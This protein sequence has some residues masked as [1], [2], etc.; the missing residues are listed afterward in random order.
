MKTMGLVISLVL[1]SWAENSLNKWNEG[2]PHH[3]EPRS[4]SDDRGGI[5]VRIDAQEARAAVEGVRKVACPL[6]LFR[7]EC[8]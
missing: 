1:R 2:A 3:L 8:G 5:E 7:A 4:G 6:F